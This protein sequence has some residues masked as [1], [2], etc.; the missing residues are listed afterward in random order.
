VPTEFTAIVQKAEPGGELACRALDHRFEENGVA[1]ERG[2]ISYYAIGALPEARTIRAWMLAMDRAAQD[3][4]RRGRI[5]AFHLP[6]LQVV[7]D[8]TAPVPGVALTSGGAPPPV[9]WSVLSRE[10][11]CVAPDVLMRGDRLPRV[12]VSPDDY[13]AMLRARGESPTL[14]LPPRFPPDMTGKV[15]MVQV[16]PDRA[17]VFVREDVCRQLKDK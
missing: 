11:G 17:P 9:A 13:A 4:L 12:P 6:S 15:V 1:I 7:G 8:G 10:E 2:V 5:T 16:R 14:G 3:D